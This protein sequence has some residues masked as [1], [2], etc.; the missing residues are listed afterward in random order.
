MI[1]NKKKAFKVFVLRSTC[2]L[3]AAYSQLEKTRYMKIP[4]PNPG[5]NGQCFLK[6]NACLN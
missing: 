5:Q 2:H 4:S 3:E 1:W 6:C